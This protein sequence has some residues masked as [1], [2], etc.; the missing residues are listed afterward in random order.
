MTRAARAPM[1]I[2]VTTYAE[3]ERIVQA[4]ASGHLHLLILLGSHGLG[5]SRMVRQALPGPSCWLQGNTS[6][7]GLYCQLW[8]ASQPV[9]GP[10]RCGWPLC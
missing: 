10:G 6:V 1:G 7:F 2:R 4:F 8:Q 5:K 3:L 9:G